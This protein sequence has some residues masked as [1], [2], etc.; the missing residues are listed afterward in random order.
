MSITSYYPRIASLLIE[1]IWNWNLNNTN[2]NT[3]NSAFNRTNLELK[4]SRSSTKQQRK[5]AFNRTN[6]ELKHDLNLTF[7]ALCQVPFNRTNLE[8]KLYFR[9]RSAVSYWPFNRTNLELKRRSRTDV[10]YAYPSLLIEP[11]WNWNMKGGREASDIL[12]TFNRTNLELKLEKLSTC[13]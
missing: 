10:D 6:L 13:L 12:K 9:W 3:R 1:P 7:C 8:L 4:R 2:R 5:S 11:I